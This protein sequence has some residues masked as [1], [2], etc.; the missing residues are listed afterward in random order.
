MSSPSAG[1]VAGL[2]DHI[3]SHHPGFVLVVFRDRLPQ[4]QHP[5]LEFLIDPEGGNMRRIVA[6]PV[7]ILRSRQSMQ[8]DDR[9]DAVAGT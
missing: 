3:V 9:V 4:V 8:V 6:V 7:L 1:R 2:I 5:V